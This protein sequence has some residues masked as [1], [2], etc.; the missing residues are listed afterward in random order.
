MGA[1]GDKRD[2]DAGSKEGRI[3][4]LSVQILETV[5]KMVTG[6]SE[7]AEKDYE[8]L[9]ERVRDLFQRKVRFESTP[10]ETRDLLAEVLFSRLRKGYAE[11]Y[12]RAR[13]DHD[14]T[15]AAEFLLGNVLAASAIAEFGR[16]VDRVLT[17]EAVPD[18]DFAGRSGFITLDELLQLLGAGKH[19]GRLVLEKPSRRLD[20]WLKDGL[21]AF[22]DPLRLNQRLIHG[23]GQTKWR[24]IPQEL[25]DEANELRT[26]EDRPIFLTLVER[27]FLK[28]DEV[29]TQQRT[30][31][32]DWIYDFLMAPKDCAFRYTACNEVPDYVV[33]FHAGL[34]VMP[35]LLEGHK[36]IDDWKRI[37]RVFPDLDEA[38]EPAPDLLARI[39]ETS[40][41]AVEIKVLS[42]LDGKN[43]FRAIQEAVGLDDFNLGMMLVRFASDGILIPPGGPDSLFEDSDL[44]LEESLEAAAQALDV[45]ESLE[46]IPESLDAVF[47][48]DEEGFGLGYLRAARKDRR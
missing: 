3:V 43:G 37:Q 13:L 4:D 6:T 39:A 2:L 47:G 45:N 12:A 35:I 15:K 29:K 19:T 30:T 9:L 23:K 44:S 5:E 41:D 1:G 24:E 14:P 25:Y 42:L 27:G 20:L 40:L 10:G 18:F 21:I 7:E 22:V 33:R 36:R 16:I 28:E 38:I 48:E 26:A 11:F 8:H 34:P 31:G 17:E 32:A 46:S